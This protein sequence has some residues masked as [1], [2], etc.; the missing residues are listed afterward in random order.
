MDAKK[1]LHKVAALCSKK[2]YC[3]SDIRRK[4]E[5][6]EVTAEEQEKIIDF[7][8]K[9]KFID[10]KR[11]AAF[12]ANDKFRFNKWGRQKI[13]RMLQLKGINR[14]D[15][16][17]ALAALNEDEYREN[18]QHL[19]EQ[20]QRTLKSNDPLKNKASLIRYALG[21]GFDYETI[22]ACLE[23]MKQANDIP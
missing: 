16:Q 13:A 3:C 20:K 17:E 8:K 9:N 6:W 12:Y 10:E 1:A 5:N 22:R 15:I 11:Y 4:L 23:K 14:D 2:E 21:K 18:C 7:L 19:L